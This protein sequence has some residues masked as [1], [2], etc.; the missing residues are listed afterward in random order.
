M[1]IPGFDIEVDE[2]RGQAAC[3][4]TSPTIFF[5]DPFLG[6]GNWDPSEAL[7]ICETCPVTQ[8]CLDYAISNNIRYG[9]WGGLRPTYRQRYAT[10]LRQRERAAS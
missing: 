6:P 8:E 5:R 2:W 10:S 7:A 3:R 4:D 9:I 1:K